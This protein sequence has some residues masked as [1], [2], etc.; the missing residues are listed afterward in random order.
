MSEAIAADLESKKGDKKSS[1]FS[2]LPQRA[3]VDERPPEIK[4]E[5]LAQRIEVTEMPPLQD[6]IPDTKDELTEAVVSVVSNLDQYN[7]SPPSNYSFRLATAHDADSILGLIKE[8]A[9]YEQSPDSVLMTREILLRDGW[10]VNRKYSTSTFR[11]DFYVYLADYHSNGSKKTVGM[12]L[13][14]QAYSTWKGRSIHLEDLFVQEDHR[15]YGLGTLLMRTVGA[16]VHEM[17]M[18]RMEWVCLTWNEK[19]RQFYNS[20]GTTE[21]SDWVSIRMEDESIQKFVH[22]G[23]PSPSS[24][25]DEME[26]PIS[27][28]ESASVS[29]EEVSRGNWNERFALARKVTCPFS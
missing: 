11:P 13:F 18:T 24:I 14:Y 9:I 26:T 8:L 29:E 27:G 21:L 28:V 7:I 23:R 17:K 19:P 20:L 3:A 16:V 25:P 4:I 10:G 1:K 2:K 12:A 5:Q 15:A 22:L 6:G